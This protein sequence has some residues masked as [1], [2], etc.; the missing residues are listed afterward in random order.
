MDNVSRHVVSSHRFVHLDRDAIPFPSPNRKRYATW[1]ALY[2]TI[3]WGKQLP[4][5]NLWFL[6]CRVFILGYDEYDGTIYR[7]SKQGQILLIVPFSIVSSYHKFG[8]NSAWLYPF[9]TS[10]SRFESWESGLFSPAGLCCWGN[11]N[12]E[13]W[14]LESMYIF[15]TIQNGT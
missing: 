3:V 7:T 14:A 15:N 13:I 5:K 11:C 2:I 8:R 10:F 6:N 9:S 1:F 12:G 4:L